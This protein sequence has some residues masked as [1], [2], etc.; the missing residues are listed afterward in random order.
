MHGYIYFTEQK[1]VENFEESAPSYAPNLRGCPTVLNRF[2]SNDAINCCDGQVVNGKC[3][4]KPA[5]TLS[6][7]NGTLP[8]C[9][10]WIASYSITKGV[11]MCPPSMPSYFE[12]D[13]GAYCT[14]SR[15]RRDMRGT[16]DPN[17]KTCVVE[18]NLDKRLTNPNSC[19]NLRILEE[20]KLPPNIN[21][22]KKEIIVRATQGKSFAIPLLTYAMKDAPTEY[23]LCVDRTAVENSMDFE[24][25]TWRSDPA[26]VKRI[27]DQVCV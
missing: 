8:R 14:A 3:K 17:A 12:N 15:L 1:N 19:Y 5:C 7:S 22:I 6:S 2:V 9:V 26:I 13:D 27:N 21:I 20:M 4:G 25:P 18:G 16:Q 24:N 23:K 11:E 10:E